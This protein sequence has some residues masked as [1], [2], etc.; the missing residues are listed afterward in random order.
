MTGFQKK[1]LVCLSY[2]YCM[3]YAR[4]AI[5]APFF[6]SQAAERGA[7]ETIV[8]FIFG[9]Y[10]LIAFLSAPI[11]GKLI[12]HTGPRFMFLCGSLVGMCVWVLTGVSG[13]TSGGPFIGLCFAVFT[14]EGFCYSAFEIS[15]MA[16]VARVY[17][18]RVSTVMGT[19][20]IFIGVGTMLASPAGGALFEWGGYLVPFVVAGLLLGSCAFVVCIIPTNADDVKSGSLTRLATIPDILVVAGVIF[21]VYLIYAFLD[22]TLEPHLTG[23]FKISQTEVGVVFMVGNGAHALAS[24]FWGWL[25]DKYVVSAP[26]QMTVG[27]L[28]SALAFTFLGPAPFYGTT[29]MI[30]EIYVAQ[31]VFGIAKSAAIVPTYAELL[32]AARAAGMPEDLGTYGVI[33]GVYDLMMNLG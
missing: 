3:G 33:S 28:V 10:S 23:K 4:S 31:V 20:E 1:V 25:A 16:T 17:P 15:L 11:I 7:S 29:G 19:M 30:W 24:P 5:M 6:P 13:Y 2:A 14:V 9:Y 12:S 8:G 21:S 22:P 26:L 18:G 27:V 32:L